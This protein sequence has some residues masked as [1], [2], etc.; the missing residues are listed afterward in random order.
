M[1]AKT[2]CVACRSSSSTASFKDRYSWQQP[3]KVWNVSQLLSH[4]ENLLFMAVY[5]SIRY[6][7]IKIRYSKLRC[8]VI[9]FLSCFAIP[10]FPC[11]R[12]GKNCGRDAARAGA[13]PADAPW[14]GTK[15]MHKGGQVDVKKV[16]SIFTWYRNFKT[17]YV[18]TSFCF[19]W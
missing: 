6:F 5:S 15:G 10:P 14:N 13:G 1:S 8:F 2:V 12:R 11:L 16:Q 3:W 4:A 17:G 19:L 7:I 9:H 18:N